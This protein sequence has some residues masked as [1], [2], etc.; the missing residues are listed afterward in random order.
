MYRPPKQSNFIDHLESVLSNLRS[1]C[2]TYILGDINICFKQKSSSLFKSYV[3]VLK[4][5]DLHQLINESTRITKTSSS[6]IDH[7]ITN[8]KDRVCQFGTISIG[9][10]DHFMTFCTRKIVKQ[11]FSKHYFSKVRCI[12]NYT[13]ELFIEK[14][15]EADWSKCFYSDNVNNSKR[16]FYVSFK[17]YC[18]CKRG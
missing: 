18:S 6:I 13:Q 16:F 7:I 5:F 1:D 11:T 10:S 4:M 3:S 8:S 12:K 17:L 2:E 15:G 9:L 14:L